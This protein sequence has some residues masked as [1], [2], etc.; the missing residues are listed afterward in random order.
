MFARQALAAVLCTVL[1]AP[2]IG[3]PTSAGSSENHPIGNLAYA[4]ATSLEGIG[5]VSGS[6]VFS[7]DTLEV[8]PRGAALLLMRGGMQVRV[9]AESRIHFAQD[10]TGALELE[11]LR[12]RA[13][14]R[15]SSSVPVIGRIA[16]LTLHPNGESSLGVIAFLS[17]KAAMVAA[18]KGSLIVNTAHDGKSYRLRE[19]EGITVAL[20]PDPQATPQQ[21]QTPSPTATKQGELK[22]RRSGMIALII[23]GVVGGIAAALI[24]TT[25]L[26]DSDKR[27]L[28]SPFQFP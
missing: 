20:A 17:D 18:E 3:Q 10:D 8:G 15:T 28:V 22:G 2:A 19:G 14:F 11:V 25:V 24:T 23:A 27:N 4:Q 7:G 21:P 6:T 26:S 13:Q 12:G 5:A 1:A 9:S 16:D